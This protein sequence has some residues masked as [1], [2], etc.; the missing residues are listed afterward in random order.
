MHLKVLDIFFKLP[1][2]GS[3]KGENCAKMGLSGC[4]HFSLWCILLFDF[5]LFSVWFKWATNGRI[6]GVL[7][8]SK[9]SW[10]ESQIAFA[11][12]VWYM[13]NLA[14][15]FNPYLSKLSLYSS[16]LML[17]TRPLSS[18]KNELLWISF[19]YVLLLV[20]LCWSIILIALIFYF[21]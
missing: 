13:N 6:Q 8:L 11:P 1:K 2:Y 5:P 7:P 19:Y 10:I 18:H 16:Q 3:G 14:Y 17:T 12:L 21:V 9:S 15:C 4:H 20:Y